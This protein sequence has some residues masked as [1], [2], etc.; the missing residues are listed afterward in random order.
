MVK[1]I[2]VYQKGSKNTVTNYRPISLLSIFV[3]TIEEVRKKRLVW[4]GFQSG[5][6]TD[7]AVVDLIE[8]VKC[9]L[10][11]NKYLV[12]FYRSTKSSGHGEY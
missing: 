1:M 10:N 3:K 4:Y 5:S 12:C 2:P 9:E 6:E 8:N 11:Q 7:S